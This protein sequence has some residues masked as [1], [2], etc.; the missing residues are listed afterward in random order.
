MY[1]KTVFIDMDGVLAHWP[2][3]LSKRNPTEMHEKNFFRSL[4]V[5]PG[6]K[7]AIEELLK[8]KDLDIYIASKHA[9]NKV[10][11]TQYCL[12]E[13]VEWVAEHFPAL[14]RKMFLVCNKLLLKGDYLIDDDM[15]WKDFPGTFLHFTENTPEQSWTNIVTYFKEKYK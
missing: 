15:R 13:K 14:T 3:A 2:P 9:V 10:G 11:P 4:G 12:S 8:L 7:E 1:R 6:A 5:Q